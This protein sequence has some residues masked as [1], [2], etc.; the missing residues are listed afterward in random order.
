MN[1]E[2]KTFGSG[3]I[4]AR[5][6]GNVGKAIGI[7][8]G[9]AYGIT[10]VDGEKVDILWG[11]L[12]KSKEPGE[13]AILALNLL[14]STIGMVD[15]E[16]VPAVVE[17]AAYRRPYGQAGLAEIRTGFFLGLYEL[18]YDVHIRPPMAIRKAAFG[19]GKTSALDLWPNINQNAADSI[20]C[21]L[22]ALL[23]I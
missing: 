23:M 1:L 4:S 14:K 17:G 21:A 9:N 19:S 15:Y 2:L 11:R 10:V 7:D 6:R 5:L 18:G 13:S 8:H 16:H 3:I 20:G 22:A 12:P